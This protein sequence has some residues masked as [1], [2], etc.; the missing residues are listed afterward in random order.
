MFLSEDPSGQSLSLEQLQA[1]KKQ[2]QDQLHSH[3]E[4][5]GMDQDQFESFIKNPSN[6][7][8]A[9]WHVI[10]QE[11]KEFN[12]TLDLLAFSQGADDNAR[13]RDELR[14]KSRWMQMK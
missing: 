3:L 6:F 12:H 11:M 2:L 5:L 4:A 10:E 1:K 8:G 14:E 7:C 9:D 13:R